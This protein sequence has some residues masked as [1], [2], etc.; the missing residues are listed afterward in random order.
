MRHPP[1]WLSP[2]LARSGVKWH[3]QW[4]EKIS[5]EAFFF[6]FSIKLSKIKIQKF[7][8][9]E[10]WKKYLMKK[11][12]ESISTHPVTPYHILIYIVLWSFLHEKEIKKG[13]LREMISLNFLLF[14]PTCLIQSKYL[15]HKIW[16]MKFCLYV[17]TDFAY[18]SIT[19]LTLIHRYSLRNC[20]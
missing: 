6:I 14:I 8:Q 5:E 9:C 7:E 16:Q 12:Q 19:K 1:I 11:K 13:S 2:V 18:N 10:K 17:P 3:T 15:F 20:I 4:S